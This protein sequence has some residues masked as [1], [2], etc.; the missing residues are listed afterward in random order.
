MMYRYRWL[1]VG[2]AFL[3]I[4]VTDAIWASFALFLVTLTTHFRWSYAATAAIFSWMLVSTALIGPLVGTVLDRMGARPVLPVGALLL[5]LGLALCSVLNSLWQF[6]AVYALLIG[7]GMSA[8]GTSANLTVLQQWFSERRGTVMGLADAGGGIGILV[9]IPVTQIVIASHGYRTAY[10]ML[11]AIVVALGVLQV[12]LLRPPPAPALSGRESAEQERQATG[13]G[14]MGD[15]TSPAE[16]RRWT[17]HRALRTG[18]FWL[19]VSGLFLLNCVINLLNVHEVAAIMETGFPLGVAAAAVGSSGIANA[20]GKLSL[21]ALSDH[22]GRPLAFGLS[23]AC[24]ITAV[25][26]LL[27][28]TIWPQPWSPY[29]FALLLGASIGVGP[30]LF[31]ALVGDIFSRANFGAIFG[32]IGLGAGAGAAIGPVLGGYLI[33]RMGSYRA[34]FAASIAIAVAAWVCFWLAARMGQSVQARGQHMATESH[35]A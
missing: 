15:T 13:P 20:L 31:A 8:V 14:G 32:L 1:M 27:A 9:L 30:P 21:G 24:I 11:A 26:V 17:I 2:L 10:L 12:L 5:A 29:V 25:A 28:A 33:D 6:Y 3:S 19:I 35:R 22:L 7:T 34:A 23:I 16:D 4:G 18:P